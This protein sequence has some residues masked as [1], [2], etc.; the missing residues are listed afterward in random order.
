MLLN[1]TYAFFLLLVLHSGQFQQVLSGEGGGNRCNFSFWMECKIGW[2]RS[3]LTNH[4]KDFK[5][6][7]QKSNKNTGKKM[8][9]LWFTSQIEFVSEENGMTSLKLWKNI[10]N[11]KFYI[12]NHFLLKWWWIKILLQIS[13]Y[14][15]NLSLGAN[16]S[17]VIINITHC[18]K[19]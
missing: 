15:M 8:W 13:E 16:W 19:T 3:T 5:Y 17:I 4:C 11:I 12:S 2:T 18:I 9:K 14:W 10:I 1:Y 7:L 6:L